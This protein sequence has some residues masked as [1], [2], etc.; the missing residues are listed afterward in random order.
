MTEQA[1]VKTDHFGNASRKSGE[2][3]LS[4]IVFIA[5]AVIAVFV[6]RVMLFQPFNIPS[7]SLVPTLL[8]GDYVFVSKYAYGYSH[9]SLPSFLDLAPGAMPGRL[10][11]AEPKR[12]DVAVFKL[13]SDGKTDYIKRVIGLPGDKIQ[14]IH[15]RLYINGIIVERTPLPLYSTLGHFG[16]PVDVPHYEE[17]LPGGVK[18][19]IIELDGDEGYWDNTPVYEVPPG[20]YF[21]MGDNRDNSTDS[22]VSAGEGG[23]GFVPFANLI[24]RAE[25]IFFS[26]DATNATGDLSRWPS[27]IRWGRLLHPVH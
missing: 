26:I 18:H 5:A 17:T 16:R 19:E 22:R 8:I 14:M 10:F 27:I 3:A 21:M 12:G 13:P 23:V 6:L 7:S 1:G 20:N 25:V 15:G 4:T 2:S 9:F 11:P 24:G